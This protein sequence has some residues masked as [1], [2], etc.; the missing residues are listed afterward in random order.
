VWPGAVLVDG[1]VLGTWR[2][3]KGKVTVFAW[4]KFPKRTVEAVEAEAQT[5]PLAEKV[6]VRWEE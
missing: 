2:R 3:T 1:E 6:T 5:L 4:G